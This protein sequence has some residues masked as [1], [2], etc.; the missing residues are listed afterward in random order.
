MFVGDIIVRSWTTPHLVFDF[1]APE[2]TSPRLCLHTA[3]KPEAR[4]YGIAGFKTVSCRIDPFGTNRRFLVP[5]PADMVFQFLATVIDPNMYNRCVGRD[6]E[7]MVV[8]SRACE[9]LWGNGV[10]KP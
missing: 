4:L 2:V 10:Q 9:A 3:L 8:I 6:E 7:G 5:C 1:I